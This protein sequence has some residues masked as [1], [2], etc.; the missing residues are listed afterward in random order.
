MNDIKLNSLRF[1]APPIAI[2]VLYATAT[3]G[4]L[5]PQ[6]A[7]EDWP[8]YLLLKAGRA[9]LGFAASFCVFAVI[10]RRIDSGAENGSV[11]ATGALMSVLF[12]AGWY[13][14]F[15]LGLAPALV[16]LD[17]S[18][19][20][21]RAP[22]NAIDYA[23][24]LGGATMLWLALHLK[25]SVSDSSNSN[26][27]DAKDVRNPPAQ[28]GAL[29]LDDLVMVEINGASKIVRIAE[30]RAIVANG[31][32]STALLGDGRESLF[33]RSLNDWESKLPTE[34]F[35]RT[36]RAAIVNIGFIGAITR[37]DGGYRIVIEGCDATAPLSR[38]KAAMLKKLRSK[39]VN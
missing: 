16:E 35:V 6:I 11:A 28:I 17:S 20:W 39:D 34:C 14:V 25:N 29:S 23:I 30:F 18:Q 19:F 31:D 10:I 26:G 24:T 12:G 38:R 4:M 8:Q 15:R 3:F 21:S 33:R 37:S 9:G 7:L 1:W 2:W 22:R 36:H 5:T 32:Y 13:A 27:A